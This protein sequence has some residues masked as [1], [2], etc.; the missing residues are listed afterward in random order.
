MGELL[1]PYSITAMPFRFHRARPDK[2]FTYVLFFFLSLNRGNDDLATHPRVAREIP[3]LP[4]ERELQKRG[5]DIGGRWGPTLRWWWI[6]RARARGELSTT[7]TTTDEADHNDSPR[8]GAALSDGGGDD[9]EMH[10]VSQG[11]TV[12]AGSRGTSKSAAAQENDNAKT[13]MLSAAAG[14]RPQPQPHRQHS[15][16]RV[17]VASSLASRPEPVRDVLWWEGIDFDDED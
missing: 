13:H 11:T 4:D 1:Q 2:N 8:R 16:S 10:N 3:A 7:T 5:V 6:E 15:V 14:V 12:A 17:S 9:M